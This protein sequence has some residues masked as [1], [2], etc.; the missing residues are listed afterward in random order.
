MR[1][2]VF[3]DT[4]YAIALSVETDEFHETAL[5][6]ADEIEKRKVGLITTRAVLLEIGNALSK[7][8]F[9]NA[10]VALLDSLENDKNVTIV[11]FTDDLYT[12]AFQLFQSRMDKEWGM[13]DCVS[14]VV[15]RQLGITESLTTDQHFQQAGFV[16]LMRL[17]PPPET[18]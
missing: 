17:N 5:E 12:S 1:D 4:A 16:S 11:P 18:H 3:L 10:A 6:L 9:R 8:Y 15:M 2:K 7:V 14:F 13:I